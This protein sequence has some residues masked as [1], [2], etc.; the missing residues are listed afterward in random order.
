M[1]SAE[2][3]ETVTA[4]AVRAKTDSSVILELWDM[5]EGLVK[6]TCGR[7]CRKDGDSRFYEYDDL[8]QIAYFGF[9][10]AIEA[11]DPTRGAFSTLLVLYIR[12]TC[13][14]EI[15]RHYGDKNPLSSARS[16]SETFNNTEDF[17]LADTLPAPGATEQYEQ[18]ELDMMADIILTEVKTLQNARQRRIIYECTYQGRTLQSFGDELGITRE[19]A[20]R[21]EKSAIAALRRRPIIR[22]IR[23]E[24]LRETGATSRELATDPYR[25]KGLT[26]YRTDFTSVVEA[27]ILSREDV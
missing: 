17:T 26:S 12:G 15:G 9:L 25:R 21:V 5:V 14:R 27:I 24:Y 10:Q 8:C 13:V 2:R 20:R 18:M 16:L 4:L 23:E 7:Y 11:F 1:D 19:G 6:S 3:R 22:A